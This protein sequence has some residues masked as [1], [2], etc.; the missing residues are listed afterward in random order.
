[1]GKNEVEYTDRST[2]ETQL[3]KILDDLAETSCEEYLH[4]EEEDNATK[5]TNAEDTPKEASDEVSN[6]TPQAPE[7]KAKRRNSKKR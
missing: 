2:D 5:D 3:D 4:Q 7:R 6:P 1:M